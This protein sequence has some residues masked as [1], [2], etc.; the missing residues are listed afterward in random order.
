[1][2]NYNNWINPIDP[3]NVTQERY[4]DSIQLARTVLGAKAVILVIYP[5]TKNVKSPTSWEAVHSANQ[6]IR[7]VTRE[8]RT[9]GYND[10]GA[11]KQKPFVL[12][13]DF[14]NYTNQLLWANARNLGYNISDPWQVSSEDGWE[15]KDNI[16]SLLASDIA[17]FGHAAQVCTESPSVKVK[18]KCLLNYISNDGM[19]WCTETIGSRFIAGLACLLGCAFNSCEEEGGSLTELMHPIG[20]CEEQCNNRFMT[21]HPVEHELIK[22]DSSLRS[23]SI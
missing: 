2:L 22:S 7:R 5:F 18:N 11:K 9:F 21:L 20:L 3:G 12:V 15:L 8:S 17:W 19:H 10:V 14:G 16:T 6:M 4:E 13:L 23:C 1:V